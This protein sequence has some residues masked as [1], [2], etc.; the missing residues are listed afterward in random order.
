M[1]WFVFV[2][3]YLMLSRVNVFAHKVLVL[4]VVND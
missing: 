2:V 3:K 1:F 4:A